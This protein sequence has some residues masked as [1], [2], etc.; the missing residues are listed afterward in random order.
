MSETENSAVLTAFNGLAV[1]VHIEETPDGPR[2][3]ID[4]LGDCCLDGNEPGS[5][6]LV[7]EGDPA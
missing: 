3:V 1:S 6:Y 5:Y 4:P 7:T 2:V